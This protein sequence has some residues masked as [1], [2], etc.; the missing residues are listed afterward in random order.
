MN[1]P[2]INVS[3]S[4]PC[5]G[6][7]GKL[8]WGR[9]QEGDVSGGPGAGHRCVIGPHQQPDFATAS[10]RLLCLPEPWMSHLRQE[11]RE[12]GGEP[13]LSQVPAGSNPWAWG[14]FQQSMVVP[15]TPLHTAR[16]L[17]ED[18]DHW[19]EVKVGGCCLSLLTASWGLE[20]GTPGW[21]LPR[22]CVISHSPMPRHRTPD[23]TGVQPWHSEHWAVLLH[24]GWCSWLTGTLGQGLSEG[25]LAITPYSFYFGEWSAWF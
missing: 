10:V 12:W 6:Q 9:R 5:G 21:W 7:S 18:R 13:V 19:D 3:A 4:V 15:Q 11:E 24:S 8:E 2:W 1:H 22:S 25:A 14:S 20:K 17:Q 16:V 23:C